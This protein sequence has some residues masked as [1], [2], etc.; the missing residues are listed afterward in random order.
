MPPCYTNNYFFEIDTGVVLMC[1]RVDTPDS[2]V[3]FVKM[4]T[5]NVKATSFAVMRM[6]FGNGKGTAKLVNQNID[7]LLLP[8]CSIKELPLKKLQ[9]LKKKYVSIPDEFKSYFPDVAD[10]V[11]GKSDDEVGEER[12]KKRR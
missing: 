10:V 5:G 11:D 12:P 9:S 2:N 3:M 8:R 1:H 7:D 4:M 6:L